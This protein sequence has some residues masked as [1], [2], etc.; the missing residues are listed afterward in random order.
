MCDRVEFQGMSHIGGGAVCGN[1]WRPSNLHLTR[2]PADPPEMVRPQRA[3]PG[4]GLID[5]HPDGRFDYQYIR[6]PWTYVA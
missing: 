4:Y 2:R 5:L 1:W 6:F 3:D